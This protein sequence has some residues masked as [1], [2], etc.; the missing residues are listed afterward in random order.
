MQRRNASSMAASIAIALMFATAWHATA[1]DGKAK[2]P[3]MAP[4]DQYL[5]ADRNGEIALARSAAPA[6]ISSDAEVLVLG[7]NGYETAVKGKNGFVCVVERGWMGPF[8]GEFA[9]N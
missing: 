6:A 2:Y 7:R 1:Q 8:D 4:L 9:V 3:S 5:M